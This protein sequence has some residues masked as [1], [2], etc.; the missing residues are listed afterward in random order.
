MSIRFKGKVDFSGCIFDGKKRFSGCIFDNDVRFNET[1][2]E[3]CDK[4][5]A[6]KI[7]F[8]QTVFNGDVIFYDAIF[9]GEVNF[10][11]AIFNE[12]LYLGTTV[13]DKMVNF[14]GV[15]F[16][17][18]AYFSYVHTPK[19]FPKKFISKN[20]VKFKDDVYFSHAHFMNSVSFCGATVEKKLSL[21][22]AIF[23]NNIDLSYISYNNED[24]DCELLLEK[25][26]LKNYV[27]LRVKKCNY[28]SLKDSIITGVI[29][30]K[31]ND[32]LEV[33]IN[34]FNL[35]DTKNLGQIYISW[36]ENNVKN[37][38][39]NSFD[40]HKNKVEQYRVL[41]ENFHNLGKYDDEDKAY[42]E[43]MKNKT[44]MKY[45][46]N[47]CDKKEKNRLY[48]YL[49]FGFKLLTMEY[50]GDYGTNPKK[51]AKTMGI[52]TLFF[53]IFYFI[54]IRFL[55]VLDE[56]IYNS[57]LRSIY[58]SVITFLTIGYGSSTFENINTDVMLIFLS[59]IEGFLGL[60]LMSYFTVA[61]VRKTL[62]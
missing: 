19:D 37:M 20:A 11:E 32:N 15:L 48:S 31:P 26:Q 45:K 29:D 59:G 61:F 5:D 33:R 60:F 1:F 42:V 39:N 2:F 7:D 10:L 18:N 17:K 8:R 58:H 52:T 54:Y 12:D 30:M 3:V 25:I 51:I 28:L 56:S 53:S 62:R 49:T 13:F 34:K 9:N 40:S 41:K 35:I 36:S 43:L 46:N 47:E 4:K 6:W 44:R 22:R 38:I 23:D 21:S 50:I 24:L 27:N 14:C 57:I 55:N 16:T